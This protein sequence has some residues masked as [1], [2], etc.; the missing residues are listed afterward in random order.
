[1]ETY[2]HDE[3][4]KINKQEED[5]LL[6]AEM[7]YKE[8]I[9]GITEDDTEN[10]TYYEAGTVIEITP[11]GTISKEKIIEKNEI[12]KNENLG[13]E[14]REQIK[15]KLLQLKEEKEN[16]SKRREF[17]LK[18]L[19]NKETLEEEKNSF[20]NEK[21]DTKNTE[22][23]NSIVAL[24]QLDQKIQNILDSMDITEKELEET[25]WWSPFK[26]IKLSKQVDEYLKALG[27]LRDR[28]E[29]LEDSL[30]SIKAEKEI[31]EDKKLKPFAYFVAEKISDETTR[32]SMLNLLT[33]TID[34]R[35]LENDQ[36]EN[37]DRSRHYIFFENHDHNKEG[38]FD[39][40]VFG[41]TKRIKN[42]K[43]IIKSEKEGSQTFVD[44]YAPEAIYKI[45]APD[46][47]II[48]DEIKGYD[49]ATKIFNEA[50]EKYA[51]QAIE[52][53]K[54]NTNI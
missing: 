35:Y 33:D 14:R 32:K 53:F 42:V 31:K 3:E 18:W 41:F 22:E 47:T 11:T 21:Q 8:K 39:F 2:L 49:E 44:Q 27:N 28:K 20:N 38:F 34:L 12:E 10:K 25:S 4:A 7:R 29:I 50:T 1:M 37:F 51:K 54:K 16:L 43:D 46:G 40:N 24:D 36:V 26:K 5:A 48:A 13:E 15:N 45:V 30:Q 6:D 52:E 19:E 23:I 9:K 17:I